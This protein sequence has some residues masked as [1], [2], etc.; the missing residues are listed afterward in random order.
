MVGSLLVLCC[1]LGA[2]GSEVVWVSEGRRRLEVVVGYLTGSE[3]KAGDL[4]YSRPGL[5]ISGALTLALADLRSSD[6]FGD[7]DLAVGFRLVVAE[8]W[9]DEAE[10]LAAV[11]ELWR[12]HNVSLIL[13]PQET[14]LHEARLAAALNIPIISYVSGK[15][16]G[17]V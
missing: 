17:K 13:G 15:G 8:T 3:R 7:L 6:F 2:K 14:C 12:V 4:E 10:S 11:A 16:S 5:T 9:G 1:V